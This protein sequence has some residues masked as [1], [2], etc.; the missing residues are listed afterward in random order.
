MVQVRAVHRVEVQRPS[1]VHKGPEGLGLAVH[2][3][4]APFLVRVVEKGAEE[5]GVQVV[6]H[7]CQE[8]LVELEGIWELLCHL[9][10]ETDIKQGK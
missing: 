4:L 3:V 7:R 9:K 1:R 10:T 8:V 6:E 5:A 2:L